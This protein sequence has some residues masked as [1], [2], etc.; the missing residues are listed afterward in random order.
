[1]HAVEAGSLSRDDV[2]QLGDVLAGTA[3]G[4]GSDA[5]I[6]IFD[7]TGLAIQDLASGGVAARPS[8]LL[9]AHRFWDVAT[10][11]AG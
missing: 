2:T 5:V 9:A 7:S 4:R 1:V 3:A 6:T 11:D 10:A 8:V